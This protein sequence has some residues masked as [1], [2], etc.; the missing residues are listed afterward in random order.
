MSEQLLGSIEAGGT[1][2]V[3]SVG[4]DQLEIVAQQTFPTTE[5][6]ETMQQVMNFFSAYELKSIGIGSFGPIDI[7]KESETY[8]F[9][10]S[11]P[12]LAWKNYDLLSRVLKDKNIPAFWTTDVNA[13]AYGEWIAGSAKGTASCVYYTVGTGIGAGAI[14]E[15]KFVE[16]YSHP[17]MG[18]MLVKR[19]ADDSFSG[20]CPYHGDCLEGVEIG[21]AHV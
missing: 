16:G 17:E 7:R 5:P 13:A 12:K 9:I 11:T 1:K 6:E 18:H 19:Q 20:V 3:C 14:Q 4:N 21:R 15:G 2:F 10:T 8:G